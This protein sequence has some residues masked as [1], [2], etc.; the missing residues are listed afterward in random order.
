M[1][2]IILCPALIVSLA[3]VFMTSCEKEKSLSELI[4]GK[5]EVEYVTQIIYESNVL[6]AEY[7]EYLQADDLTLQLVAGGTGIY[8]EA[9][10]DFLFSWSFNGSTLTILDLSQEPLVWNLEM[11]GDK[12][13]WS[14]N[15]ANADDPTITYKYLFTAKKVL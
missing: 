14:Y 5:W 1:K 12:L 3:L 10:D 15:S 11:N 13:V 9:G 7:K 4:I 6:K 8:S 2:K